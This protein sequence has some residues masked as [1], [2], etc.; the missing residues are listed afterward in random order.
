MWGVLTDAGL[1]EHRH[2]ALYADGSGHLC[3]KTPASVVTAAARVRVTTSHGVH[4]VLRSDVLRLAGC[5]TAQNGVDVA[6]E[7]E[8]YAKESCD[9]AALRHHIGLAPLAD[10][11]QAKGAYSQAQ[12]A[13]EQAANQ[14]SLQ[15]ASLALLMGLPADL[16]RAAGV[17]DLDTMRP[18]SPAAAPEAMAKPGME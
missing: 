8:R 4:P 1:S 16:V 10:E 11:L 15:Q 2:T 12:L 14:L 17:L 6:K 13:P 3:G 7:S 9:A 18:E 5:L